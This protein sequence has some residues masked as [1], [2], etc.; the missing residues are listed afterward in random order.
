MLSHEL[1]NPLGAVRMAVS[2]LSSGKL[3][4]DKTEKFWNIV[5]RQTAHM[6]RLLDDLLDISRITQEKLHLEF[7]RVDL[8]D[9][10]EDVVQLGEASGGQTK[11]ENPSVGT[12]RAS[13]G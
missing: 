12:G 8:R 9:I 5:D 4:E 2:I 11:N 3:E 6:T 13:L 7:E 10:V 1:R